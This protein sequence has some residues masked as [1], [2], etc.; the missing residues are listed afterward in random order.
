MS[1]IPT[2]YDPGAVEDRIYAMWESEGLFKATPDPDKKPFTIMIPLPN[3]TGVLHMGHALNN[4]LQDLVIRFKRM[5]GYEA[6]WQP[7]TDH[8]GVATQAVVERMLWKNERKTRHDLGREKL[9]KR[10]WEW[11]D[12]HGDTIFKQLKKLGS[13]CDW[14]RTRFTM[15]EVISKAVRHA[16]VRL[17]KD[18][19]IY[20]G[21]RLVNWSCPLGTALSNDELEYKTVKTHFWHI[22]YP[23]EGEPG[24]YVVIATTRPETML[25]DTA[26]AVH[27]EDERYK[28][29]IGKTVI[30]PLLDRPIPVVADEYVKRDEGTGCLKVTPAHDPNDFE[31][32][33]RHDLEFLN[34][35]NDDG[36]LNENAGPYAGMDRLKAR[37]EVVK[38]LEEAE[39]LEKVVDHTHE[40]AHCYRSGDII[41]PFLSDQWFV[42]MA[43]FVELARK[44]GHDGR[45]TFHPERWTKT[46]HQWLD[47]T[48]DWCISRQIWWGHRIP[49]WTCEAC[50]EVLCEIEDPTACT[51]CGSAEL[52][53]DPD[54]LDTWFSSQLWPF[55]T[56]GWPDDN[57]DLDFFYPTNLLVTDRGIIA[58]W[59]ARMVM[60]G[61][62]L[63]G[64]EPYS[65]VY[66]HGT[67]LDKT[68]RRMSKSLGN[69]IDPLVMI[70][71]GK[72]IDGREWEG[73]G[74]DAV[75][76]TLATMT[77]EGQD[78]RIWPERFKEGQFFC[79]KIWNASRFTMMNIEG[80][81]LAGADGEFP[82]DLG[83][84]G[85]EDRWILSRLNRTIRDA[86]AELERFKFCNFAQMVRDFVWNEFCAWTLELVKFRLNDEAADPEDAARARR[87]VAHVLDRS[88]RLLHPVAPFI[89]EEIFGNLR[90]R[91][92][93][94]SLDGAS[95]RDEARII[96]A[97]WPEADEGLIN[98]RVE[99]EMAGIQE[100]IRGIRNIRG[101]AQIHHTVKLEVHV[102]ADDAETAEGLARHAQLISGIAGCA[103][104]K[105]GTDVTK[106]PQSA[107]EV[108]TGMRLFVPLAGVIDIEGEVKRHE[109]KLEKLAK[110]IESVE[111]KLANPKFTEKAPAEIIERERSA[112]NELMANKEEILGQ[113]ES[114]KKIVTGAIFRPRKIAPVTI[115]S[116]SGRPH[117]TGRSP[118]P[119]CTGSSPFLFPPA[120]AP[121]VF[122]R[123]RAA[124]RWR[125]RR[126]RH[127]PRG[128]AGRPVHRR[129]PKRWPRSASQPTVCLRPRP[130]GRRCRRTHGSRGRPSGPLPRRWPACPR[131]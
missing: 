100:V 101:T 20:R 24:R 42:K 13:S 94:R 7:G 50:G 64:K 125:G 30:L 59:V 46:Y 32:G 89:T 127:R 54:V 93:D 6:C 16:F 104:A 36:T 38:A 22:R 5:Q 131:P 63:L 39:L 31:I 128:R 99:R 57:P 60:M 88:L 62:Y 51:K 74:A 10:I 56:M 122:L 66:I 110:R 126:P 35:L 76:F 91:V 29:L 95:D 75:R 97:A 80:K 79:N 58:L 67:I 69:G 52:T 107:A 73:F 12:V 9:L 68:G 82:M 78:L 108:L 26:V 47:T 106:P 3:V 48:P 115:F 98:D 33:K 15:D 25:G 92:P 14:D 11:K 116:N 81:A 72:D 70:A 86:T 49:V 90:D 1:E 130:R 120:R 111:R 84:L 85:F 77:T 21:K 65:D 112:L 44:A 96:R 83:K 124:A 34:I 37:P 45:V 61:E 53:R 102:Q 114:L 71:G 87:V 27:P 17:F 2:T 109:K 28:D 123:F 19:L 4:T 41:E 8:A 105:V 40:V 119:R 118:G 103:L 129:P 18:G 117:G 43:P 113:I 23:I 55:A 121:F